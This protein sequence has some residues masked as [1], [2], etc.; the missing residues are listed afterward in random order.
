VLATSLG[1]SI[2]V[3]A[4]GDFGAAFGAARLGLAATTGADPAGVCTPPPVADVVEPNREHSA[5]FAEA[6]ERFRA[7]YPTIRGA[8]AARI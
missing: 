4:A 2:E 5:A 7:L 1:V 8:R 6:L 3:P